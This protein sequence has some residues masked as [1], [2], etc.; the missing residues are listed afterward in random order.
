MSFVSKL[1]PRSLAER[2]PVPAVY[3]PGVIGGFGEQIQSGT[4]QR[5]ACMWLDFTVRQGGSI[6]F[7]YF[8]CVCVF[9]VEGAKESEIFGFSEYAGHSDQE[10]GCDPR[11]ALPVC[12]C[13]W[14]HSWN[15]T[16]R[17]TW[18]IYFRPPWKENEKKKNA[19]SPC[20][21]DNRENR[22]SLCWGV[23]TASL[24]HNLFCPSFL[25]HIM[26]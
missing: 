15:K 25:T 1:R 26:V 7:I 18:R 21:D 12:L 17:D 4:E 23:S 5:Y 19:S 9:R 24:H 13:V 6:L 3:Y 22:L 20:G 14:A 10:Q 11:A 2:S 8:F 16:T